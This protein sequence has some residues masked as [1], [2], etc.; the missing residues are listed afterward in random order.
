M[1][2]PLLQAKHCTIPIANHVMEPKE[3]EMV[4]KAQTD[5]SLFY[6]TKVGRKDMPSYKTKIP[7]AN[8]MWAVV[9]YMRTFK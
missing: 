1:Q 8:D 3:K 9:N 6:K 2:P 4:Q 7:D 5:G